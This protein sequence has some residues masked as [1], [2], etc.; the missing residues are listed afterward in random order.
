MRL[1]FLRVPPWIKSS[2]AALRVPPWTKSSYAVLRVPPRTKDVLRVLGSSLKT[3]NQRLKTYMA[4]AHN[5]DTLAPLTP[6]PLT[7]ALTP[8]R[9]KQPA[10]DREH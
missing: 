10:C 9:A 2:S 1:L 6:G 7:P 4:A 3:K 5:R 8:W